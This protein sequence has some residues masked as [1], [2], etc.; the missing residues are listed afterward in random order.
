MVP[1]NLFLNLITSVQ[2]MLNPPEK[3]RRVANRAAFLVLLY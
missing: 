3:E 1:L 2:N